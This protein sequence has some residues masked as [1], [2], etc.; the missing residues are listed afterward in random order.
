MKSLSTVLDVGTRVFPSVHSSQECHTERQA[1][2]ERRGGL[3]F[4]QMAFEIEAHRDE[5]KAD[6]T[7]MTTMMDG[8]RTCWVQQQHRRIFNARALVVCA[9]GTNAQVCK[10]QHRL[11]TTRAELCSSKVATQ[12]FDGTD[13]AW[14]FH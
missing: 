6:K 7:L 13:K 14:T 8:R 4:L 2:R 12:G 3:R 9:V 10:S 11:A 5:M 1:E